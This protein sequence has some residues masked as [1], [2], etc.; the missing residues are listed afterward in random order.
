MGCTEITALKEKVELLEA[1]LDGDPNQMASPEQCRA[2]R[3]SAVRY[4]D[5]LEGILD[6]VKDL[7]VSRV[8]HD[9]VV[10]YSALCTA[11]KRD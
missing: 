3:L 7:T 2:W 4:A 5:K 10:L 6:A 1:T 9:A 8:G 11:L